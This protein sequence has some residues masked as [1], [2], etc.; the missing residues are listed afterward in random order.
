L[1]ANQAVEQQVLLGAADVDLPLKDDAG[2]RIP[3]ML[4]SSRWLVR[5][6]PRGVSR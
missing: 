1:L 6:L 3:A 5:H 4:T 2:S